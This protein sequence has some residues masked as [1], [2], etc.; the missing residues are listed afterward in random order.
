[1]STKQTMGI[2][3][4]TGLVKQKFLSQHHAFIVSDVWARQFV[5]TVVKYVECQKKK[6]FK[7]KK[8]KLLLLLFSNDM[9]S[10]RGK[11][12]NCFAGSKRL[13]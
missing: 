11:V 8:N 4:P 2:A 12:Y 7:F 9:I 3:K 1:M 5:I 10:S 13:L 6:I